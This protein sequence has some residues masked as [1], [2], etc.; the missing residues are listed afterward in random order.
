MAVLPAAAINMEFL[1]RLVGRRRGVG[2]VR[3][4]RV[5]RRHRWLRDLANLS[6]GRRHGGAE[7]LALPFAV[8]WGYLIWGDFPDLFTYSA[9]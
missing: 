1:L 3:G 8:L 5:H 6:P 9:R 2:A 4:L 7:Y